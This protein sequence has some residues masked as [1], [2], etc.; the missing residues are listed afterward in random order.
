[1]AKKIV[2]LPIKRQIQKTNRIRVKITTA[3]V[4]IYCSSDIAAAV[5]VYCERLNQIL[6]PK[7]GRNG[8]VVELLTELAKKKPDH[9]PTSSRKVLV[10]DDYA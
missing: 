7:K 9:F 3:S 1:M 6:V 4:T 8:D 10:G 5:R 2:A